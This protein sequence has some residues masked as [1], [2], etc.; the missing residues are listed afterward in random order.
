MSKQ[1]PGG[2]SSFSLGWGAD[3]GKAQ[4]FQSCILHKQRFRVAFISKFGYYKRKEIFSVL[5]ISRNFTIV[6][7][8]RYY[9]L[10]FYR[11]VAS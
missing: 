4:L 3:T 9:S 2:A 1:A 8:N 5:R 7:P 10:C 6:F 11:I